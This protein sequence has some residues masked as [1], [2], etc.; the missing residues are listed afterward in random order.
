V[1]QKKKL[2]KG[3]L[4]QPLVAFSAYLGWDLLI[5]LEELKKW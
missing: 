4:P 2:I 3:F 1:Q 5:V